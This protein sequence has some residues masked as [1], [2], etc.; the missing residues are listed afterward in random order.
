MIQ[1]KKKEVEGPKSAYEIVDETIDNGNNEKNRENKNDNEDGNDSNNVN[2][3]SIKD[4][5]N[6]K[7]DNKNDD[8]KNDDKKENDIDN[9]GEFIPIIT[10]DANDTSKNK[11]T[12]E[13]RYVIDNYDYDLAIKYEKRN[14][15][16][17]FYYIYF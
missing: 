14:F 3:N 17:L 11:E 7:S 10:F 6:Q 2:K 13:S 5:N 1:K 4:D 15:L 16:K 12:K 8:N 9:N